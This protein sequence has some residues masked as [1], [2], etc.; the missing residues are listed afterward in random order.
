MLW[1]NL[2]ICLDLLSSFTLNS[3]GKIGQAKV[4]T[5]RYRIPYIVEFV[6]ES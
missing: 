1:T 4:L 5:M 2:T 3:P 6:H